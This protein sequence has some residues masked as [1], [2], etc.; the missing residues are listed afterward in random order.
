[1][2]VYYDRVHKRWVGRLNYVIDGKRQ[3]PGVVG[4]TRAEATLRLE[5]LR[6]K[7]EDGERRLSPD[8]TTVAGYLTHWVEEI[9]VESSTR[10]RYW[11]TIRNQVL[12]VEWFASMNLSSLGSQSAKQKIIRLY[13]ELRAAGATDSARRKVHTTLHSAFEHA[14]HN[15]LIAR[16]PCDIPKNMKPKYIRPDAIPLTDLQ[17]PALLKAAHDE[18]IESVILLALDSGARQGELFALDWTDLDVTGRVLRIS[19]NVKDGGKVGRTKTKKTR[20]LIIASETIEALLHRRAALHHLGYR[21]QVMFPDSAGGRM[22]RQNFDRRVWQRLLEKAE[23]ESGLSFED[24][25]FHTLRHTCATMLLQAGEPIADVAARLGHSKVS[26]TLDYY[27]HALPDNQ[28]PADRFS[29]RLAFYGEGQQKGQHSNRIDN[30]ADKKK[31]AFLIGRGFSNVPRG[32]I[33]LPTPGFSD[34]CSTN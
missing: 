20:A 12:R 10:A 9:E 11:S 28:R 4:R 22:R 31:P 32:R 5:Q 30:P 8:R 23:D 14:R 1:M 29:A 16:Q 17:E 13:T 18:P 7:V 15:G 3:R 19:H 21:G 2:A 27:A 25:V 6:Q 26:T 34:L 24:V 33:E